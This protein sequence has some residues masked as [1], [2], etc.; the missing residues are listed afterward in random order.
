MPDLLA[1]DVPKAQVIPRPAHRVMETIWQQI[2]VF[3]VKFMAFTGVATWLL[4][5][6]IAMTIKKHR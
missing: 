5:L 3:A 2:Y 4:V 6:I 1:L